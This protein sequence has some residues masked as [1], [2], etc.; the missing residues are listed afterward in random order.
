[1]KDNLDF[2]QDLFEIIEKKAKLKIHILKR[3]IK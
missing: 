3:T 1:M 2:L